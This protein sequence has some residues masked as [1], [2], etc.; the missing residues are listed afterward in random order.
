MLST[1]SDVA[2]KRA[3][4][5]KQVTKATTRKQEQHR[6]EKIEWRI[7]KWWWWWWKKKKENT[8]FVPKTE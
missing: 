1:K 5:K 2:S 8:L 4:V 6:L 3:K 7:K